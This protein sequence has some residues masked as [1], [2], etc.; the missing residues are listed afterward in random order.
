[1]TTI[2]CIVLVES[3]FFAAPLSVVI[4]AS[5]VSAAGSNR[6]GAAPS[7]RLMSKGL[8]I[9][10]SQDIIYNLPFYFACC[11][12]TFFVSDTLMQTYNTQPIMCGGQLSGR[13]GSYQPAIFFPFLSA[14]VQRS[15]G[16]RK[17]RSESPVWP[18]F[19]PPSLTSSRSNLLSQMTHCRPHVLFSGEAD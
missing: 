1:V 8:V 19:F 12:S 10:A 17:G 18:P 3:F 5:T 16:R 15:R 6:G 11:G 7:R 13:W 4:Q 14:Q 9:E 2:H